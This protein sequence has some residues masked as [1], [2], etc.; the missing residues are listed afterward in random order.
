[1]SQ[2]I[3][4]KKTLYELQEFLVGWTLREI[5][6]LFD[7]ADIACDH[8]FTPQTNGQRRSLVAQYYHTLDLS[9]WGDVRKLL[10]VFELVLTKLEDQ[11]AQ[12]WM[13]QANY[14]RRA[15]DNLAKWLQKDGFI[16]RDG[17]VVSAGHLPSL[18]HLESIAISADV[19][20]ILTQLE[21]IETAVEADPPL[22]IGTAKELVE[23][24]CKTILSDR[25]KEAET[26]WDLLEL[27]KAV[28]KE[29]KLTPDDI[30]DAAQAAATVK[31]LLNNLA[32]IVQG[33][34][35]LRNPYGTGH[36]PEGRTKGLGP[37]HA[38]L[39]AGAASTLAL[40]LF[41]THRDQFKSKAP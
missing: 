31:R 33:L 8:D 18:P 15:T 40:F 1:M 20:Y 23:T 12:D 2:P 13:G 5:Q 32:T 7:S 29:L 9:D 30:P 11:I 22:A 26:G 41:E 36:G 4:S 19:P 25:G 10:K 16:F 28:R 35:E 14:A 24:T 34:A 3:V 38:R 21:R 17:K 39:A 27:C 6:V 37:R